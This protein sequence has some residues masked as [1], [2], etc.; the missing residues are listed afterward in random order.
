MSK[1]GIFKPER[2][3]YSFVL[4]K[5]LVKTDFILRYQGSALGYL[6][7]LVK[8]LALFGILYLVFSIFLRVGDGIPNFPVYLLVGIV[9]W[10][11]FAE[12]TNN[13][14]KS[15]TVHSDLLR[16]INFPKYV[17]VL[18][19]AF[20]AFINLIINMFV[21]AIFIYFN[22]IS[23]GLDAFLVILLIA[24]LFI[25][26]LALSFLLSAAY[27][28]YRDVAYIWELLL[29]A[30]FYATPI[31]Y[32]MQMVPLAAQ[33]VLLMN[34][35]AQIIQDV[36]FLIVTDQAT[37]FESSDLG[38]FGWARIIPLSLVVVILVLSGMYFRNQSKYFAENV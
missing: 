12:V 36:R 33:K 11:Y 20:S 6:W 27:V 10:T 5:Q 21:I 7:S 37:T 17:I 15:M 13:S 23:L 25:F 34:P 2:Y 28:K 26:G 29:Q 9:L 35:M 24:E 1:S 30:G 38:S 32:P 4:L 8:P 31:L 14:V 18:A 16:K 19:S 22:N 3:R